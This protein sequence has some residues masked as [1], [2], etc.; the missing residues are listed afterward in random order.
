M[1]RKPVRTPGRREDLYIAAFTLLT[2][3]GIAWPIFDAING[4]HP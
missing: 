4:G 2:L 1:S 3:A